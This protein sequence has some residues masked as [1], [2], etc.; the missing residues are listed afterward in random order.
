MHAALSADRADRLAF[1]L[2]AC[3]A[4]LAAASLA[5]GW[6]DVAL[7]RARG[8]RPF[9]FTG[10]LAEAHGPGALYLGILLHNLGLAGILPGM[11]FLLAMRE[12][13]PRLRR[14][15][16]AI[17]LAALVLALAN[18]LAMLLAGARH[19]G[20]DLRFPLALYLAEAT[21]VLGVGLLAHR[22]FRRWPDAPPDRAAVGRA[23]RGMGAALFAAAVGLALLAGVETHA[24]LGA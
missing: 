11:G 5:Q 16:P 4:L 20:L 19:G 22:A 14:A 8:E 1:L 6:L 12:P 18:T 9:A 23:F 13:R 15:I 7:P 3:L 17:L 10:G 2:A 21:A 24:L